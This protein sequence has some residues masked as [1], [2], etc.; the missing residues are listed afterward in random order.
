[1]KFI[2]YGRQHIDNKDI[3]AVKKTLKND[4]ITTG[5]EVQKFEKLFAKKVG[6]KYAVTCSNATVGLLLSYLSLEIKENE[7]IIM[8][9]INFIASANM[10]RFINAKIFL[11]DV[12]PITGRMRPED[13]L[14]CIKINNIKKINTLVVM[15]HGGL[16][17]D[18]KKFYFLK[19]KYKFNI[20]EDACHALGARYNDLTNN[21]VGNSKYSDLSVFSFHPVKN[22]TTGEGGM[23]TT[24]N[25]KLYEK[26]KILKNHG[27]VR[28]KNN[29]KTYNWAYQVITGG[30]N[31]RLNDFQ[32]ALG[33][34]QLKKLD[35]FINRRR[36]IAK[37]Y[38]NSFSSHT[39]LINT[40]NSYQGKLSA[41]HLFIIKLNLKKIKITRNQFIKKLFNLGI[42]TQVHYI[43]IF[44]FPYYKKKFKKKY[45]NNAIKYFDSCVS[46][47]IF[48]GMTEIDIN[49]VS[50]QIKRI[51]QEYKK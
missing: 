6:V 33:T 16:P 20:I 8:P 51:I 12:D 48:Y 29:K 23:V 21:K 3:N 49:Y 11:T 7:I 38:I 14:E 27:I 25:R 36:A 34:S 10:A 2:P 44:Y 17:C 13:L 19:K 43:P 32:C 18:M 15:H 47:P 26:L 35:K 37:K 42:V 31:F 30:F 41:F 1:M 5:S 40:L 9:S 39:N 45:F 28:K 4:L 50:K 24:N 22:I 46:I